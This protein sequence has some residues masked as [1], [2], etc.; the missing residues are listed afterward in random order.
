MSLKSLKL[1]KEVNIES[2]SQVFFKGNKILIE[3]NAEKFRETEE[4]EVGYVSISFEGTEN[5]VNSGKYSFTKVEGS[6]DS[7]ILNLQIRLESKDALKVDMG[8]VDMGGEGRG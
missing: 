7:V 5:M 4:P 8:K 1:D 3:I 6:L 2:P